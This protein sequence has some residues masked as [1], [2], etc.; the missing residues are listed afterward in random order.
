MSSADYGDLIGEVERL[1][2]ALRTKEQAAAALQVRNSALERELQLQSSTVQDVRLAKAN[3]EAISMGEGM[4]KAY[5]DAAALDNTLTHVQKEL[6]ATK[7]QLGETQ[8]VLDENLYLFLLTGLQTKLMGLNAHNSV[9]FRSF[10]N[11]VLES[12]VSKRIP[13]CVAPFRTSQLQE[14]HTYYASVL[15]AKESSLASLQG[16]LASQQVLVY[17]D[18]HR[19]A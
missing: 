11:D 6:A 15:E 19:D 18:V 14:L 16:L 10:P 7:H 9:N 12:S 4:R 13:G 17:I 8:H 1:H 2:A 5:S 3:E